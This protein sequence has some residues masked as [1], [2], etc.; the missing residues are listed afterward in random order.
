MKPFP[1][2]ILDWYT[3]SYD[4]AG[5]LA[6]GLG[7]VERIRIREL[8]Q[9]HL[10]APPAVIYDVGGGIGVHAFWLAGLGYE[11]HLVDI[12]PVHIEHARC[13]LADPQTPR[14]ASLRVGDARSLEYADASADAVL[15]FGPLYHLTEREDRLIALAEARRV[16][17]PGGTLFAY[18]ISRYASTIYGLRN[19]LA[20]DADYLK[21]IVEELT[22]GQ[23]R[24]P[25]NWNVFTTAYFHH[26]DDLK[27][28]LEEA[29]FI[30][31][32][33]LGIQGPGW[34]VPEFDESLKN[35]E[36]REIVLRIAQLMER[37]PVMSP[38]M[39]AVARR[40]IDKNG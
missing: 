1:K 18:A 21:M 40:P 4:E 7:L 11:V 35:D 36:Q 31:I 12:V 2:E 17:R 9:R 15:L 10:C 6:E 28:E 23:H 22:T 32:E 5:R 19:G 29:G 38:H 20:W 39:V 3:N 37:E 24:K 33:T 27:E 25:T 13:K 14:L 34:I 30:H 8:I 16:L 26:P